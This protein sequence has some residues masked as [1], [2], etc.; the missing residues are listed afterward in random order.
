MNEDQV[1]LE[2]QTNPVSPE[3]ADIPAATPE[4]GSQPNNAVLGEQSEDP[5]IDT[6]TETEGNSL[7]EEK[8]SEEIIA[9][10]Q[11]DLAS[12]RQ[13]LAEQSEQLDSFK[14]RYVALA[15]EFDN[16]R[17]RTQREKEEQAK[18]IK[19]RTIT[20][21]LP[22]VDNF[23]R[24]RTQIKPNSEGENQIHKSYQGVYKNLVDSLK[25]L[26]VAPMRPEGK[27]FD[28]KYHEAMLRE[29]TAEYPEDTVIEELVRG[30]LLDDMVLRHS[31]VKVAVAPEEGTEL[32]NGEERADG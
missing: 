24:A 18:V 20:E 13:E 5:G 17:K 6:G 22:V 15:A 1:S 29:P 2:N 4:E 23:E 31:M 27:P 19:G 11:K 21:L 26:G 10:L 25:S 12:H 8:S 32:E 16:F 7:E 9:I 28:P 30:Y 14:K 3:A